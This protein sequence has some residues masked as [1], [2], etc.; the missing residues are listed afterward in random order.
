MV[1]VPT[2]DSAQVAPTTQGVDAPTVNPTQIAGAQAQQ[3]GAQMLDA[4]MTAE[5]AASQIMHQANMLQVQD[6]QNKAVLAATNLKVGGVDANGQPITGYST[7][8]GKNALAITGNDGKVG[9][10]TQV[11]GAKLNKSLDDIQAGLSNPEQQAMFSNVRHQLSNRFQEEAAG[12]QAQQFGVWRQQ[13]NSDALQASANAV[14]ADPANADNVAINSA[15]ARHTVDDILISQ[16]LAGP[17]DANGNIT[18]AGD[19]QRKAYDVEQQTL[20]GKF[21]STIV[22]SLVDNGHGMTALNYIEAHKGDMTT[23]DYNNLH[24]KVQEMAASQIAIGNV[25]Q[26]LAKQWPGQAHDTPPNEESVDAQFRQIAGTNSQLL[27]AMRNEFHA[28]VQDWS[29]NKGQQSDQAKNQAQGDIASGKSLSYL[30]A[31]PYWN[32][33][34]GG[35]QLSVIDQ[36]NNFSQATINRATSAGGRAGD[37]DANIINYA[38]SK[39]GM[40]EVH[41]RALAAISSGE[42][43]QLD[44]TNNAGGGHGAYGLFQIRDS[45]GLQKMHAL[46]GAHPTME[47]QIDF[48]VNHNMAGGAGTRFQNAS[49]EFDAAR[50]LVQ[51]VQRAGSDNDALTARALG[52]LQASGNAK[53]KNAVQAEQYLADPSQVGPLSPQKVAM[54]TNTLGVYWAPKVIAATN[55]YQGQLTKSAIPSAPEIN[56]AFASVGIN[57]TAKD[58][59]TAI[60]RGNIRSAVSDALAQATT[61]KGKP[62]TIDER[63]QTIQSV[64]ATTVQQS[65]MFGLWNSNT[66]LYAVHPADLPNVTIPQT[67]LPRVVSGMQQLYQQTRNPKYAPTQQNLH[68]YYLAAH[69]VSAPSGR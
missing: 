45:G 47:Q 19:D 55:H 58:N 29:F 59:D 41:A 61:N 23:I 69:H 12:Y 13:S 5:S 25:D 36:A 43:G 6:A 48:Y 20:M 53:S 49:N 14:A 28:R 18:F 62:L 31:Q 24:G 67:E 10:L 3:S 22:N 40:D 16:G 57:P 63:N 51:D 7:Y 33:L 27:G 38:M 37:L 44:N 21:H 52:A 64:T 66:N 9:P 56:S 8:V 54:L 50:Y 65:H 34:Q 42:G 39:Y 46:Y 11:Y 32:K 35:D 15:N 4:G 17:R 60:M 30:K 26:V 2:Y 1:R 68:D